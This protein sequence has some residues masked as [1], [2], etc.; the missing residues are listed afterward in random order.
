M[1]S[2]I[3]IE[4][5]KL[6]ARAY[7]DARTV[8]GRSRKRWVNSPGTVARRRVLAGLRAHGFWLAANYHRRFEHLPH[9]HVGRR[10]VASSVRWRLTR[11]SP[12]LSGICRMARK[13]TLSV[14]NG[15]ASRRVLWSWD[16]P[17]EFTPHVWFCGF[18][19]GGTLIIPNCILP[20]D[21]KRIRLPAGG[22]WLWRCT[23]NRL[24]L[25]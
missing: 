1:D 2:V 20:A 9:A 11:G 6:L 19:N 7:R 15:S 24:H 16:L 14:A 18:P 10:K 12:T 21:W 5:S 3:S 25:L 4:P 13:K 17:R 8:C 22:C 23:K